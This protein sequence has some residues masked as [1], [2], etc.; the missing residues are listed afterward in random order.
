MTIKF[1]AAGIGGVKEAISNL[2]EYHSFGLKSCEI[3]FT[4]GVYIKK[5]DARKIG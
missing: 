3:A 5:E 4:Y 2:E 1:G